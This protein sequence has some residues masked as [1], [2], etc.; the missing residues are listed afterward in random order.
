[1]TSQGCRD[2]GSPLQQWEDTFGPGRIVCAFPVTNVHFSACCVGDGAAVPLQ[3]LPGAQTREEVHSIPK[4]PGVGENEAGR[5]DLRQFNYLSGQEISVSWVEDL[6]NE[7]EDAT[8]RGL[9]STS[10]VLP[11]PV[12]AALLRSACKAWQSWPALVEVGEPH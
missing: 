8:H 1:M 10:H 9:S 11:G 12:L 4:A 2:Y 7:L 5:S 6:S 3:Q